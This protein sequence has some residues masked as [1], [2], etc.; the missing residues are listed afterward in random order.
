MARLARIEPPTRHGRS[1]D[2]KIFGIA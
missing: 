1:R 2:R